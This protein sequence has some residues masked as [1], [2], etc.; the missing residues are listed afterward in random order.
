MN[1]ELL[2]SYW[3]SIPI[4]KENAIDYFQLMEQWTK[5]DR[6]VRKILHELS[7]YDNGDNY[8]LIRSARDGG[9]LYRTQN[10]QDI[11]AY[12]KECFNMARSTFAP[13]E[14]INRVLNDADQVE[15]FEII[16]GDAKL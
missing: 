13:L 10:E 16:N 1:K 4:G 7:A 8:I 5:R 15:L 3:E 14:K 9:G 6:E 12:R 11:K 2:K